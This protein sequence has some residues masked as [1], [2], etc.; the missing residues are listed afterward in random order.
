VDCGHGCEWLMDLFYDG[1]YHTRPLYLMEPREHPVHAILSGCNNHNAMALESS[2][3]IW[4]PVGDYMKLVP[5]SREHGNGVM[6]VFN[7]A[8][9]NGWAA[10]QK[11]GRLSDIGER[12]GELFGVV[13][14]DKRI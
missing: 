5:M 2:S 9:T 1:N 7:E 10:F 3:T 11:C 8:I 12:K 14:Y 4:N 6:S 13:L